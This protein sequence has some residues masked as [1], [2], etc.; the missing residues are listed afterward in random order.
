MINLCD[1]SKLDIKNSQ[2][3]EC[4]IRESDFI[5]SNLSSSSFRGSIL[6]ACKFHDTNLER[7]SFVES[8][9]YYIDPRSNK[10]K[11]AEFSYSEALLLLAPLEIKIKY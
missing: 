8:K 1:F 10:L 3:L 11:G 7:A 9:G 5:G 6:E 4:E 2:F